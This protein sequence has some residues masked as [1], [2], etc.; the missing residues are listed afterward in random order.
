VNTYT[1]KITESARNDMEKIYNYIALDLFSP[2]AAMNQY[3]RIANAISSL[4]TMPERYPLFES[5]PERLRGI[6]KLVV[7]NYIVCYIVDEKEVV[8]IA[9]FYG[10]SDVSAKLQSR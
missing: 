7:D 5:K 3:N 2:L 8:I 1:V 6:R 9:I 4:K 10:A